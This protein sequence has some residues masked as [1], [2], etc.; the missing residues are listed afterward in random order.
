M[1]AGSGYSPAKSMRGFRCLRAQPSDF[2]FSG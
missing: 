1:S 2:I